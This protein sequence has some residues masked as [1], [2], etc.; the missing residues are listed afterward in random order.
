MVICLD[1][2]AKLSAEEDGDLITLI[3]RIHLLVAL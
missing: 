1:F 2:G 3:E